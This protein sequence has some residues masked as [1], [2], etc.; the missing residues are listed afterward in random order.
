MHVSLSF[1][2]CFALDGAA[3]SRARFPTVGRARL[4][5]GPRC[6]VVSMVRR[7]RASRGRQTGTR[8]W[9]PS[10]LLQPAQ[11]RPAPHPSLPC[12]SP[13]DAHLP[14]SIT[15]R[16]FTVDRAIA[17]RAVC[18]LRPSQR[19]TSSRTVSPPF[20]PCRSPSRRPS[21]RLRSGRWMR[22][23]AISL[24]LRAPPVGLSAWSFCF[25]SPVGWCSG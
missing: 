3:V 17:Y 7:P 8:G 4:S 21:L 18:D 6:P 15:S 25:W 11:R 13:A 22:C 9:P 12:Q 1:L 19:V 5:R 24:G 2:L 16:D 20:R 14:P 23:S 10:F